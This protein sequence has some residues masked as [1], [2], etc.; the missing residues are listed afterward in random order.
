MSVQ[1]IQNVQILY[2]VGFNY[3]EYNFIFLGIKQFLLKKGK[4]KYL[5]LAFFI[6]KIIFIINNF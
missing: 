1:N 3:F 6:R 4:L 5:V 2:R